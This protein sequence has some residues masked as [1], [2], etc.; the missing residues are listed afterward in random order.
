MKLVCRSL[1]IVISTVFASAL[2]ASEYED[3]WYG[4]QKFLA[5]KQTTD[6][7]FQCGPIFK[8]K[9]SA[10]Y[11]YRIVK[12]KSSMVL[13]V[14]EENQ[15]KALDAKI[16]AKLI[17]IK[18]SNDSVSIYDLDDESR[19]EVIA[20]FKPFR[21]ERTGS[22][23]DYF[24]IQNKVDTETRIN[25]SSGTSSHRFSR[26]AETQKIV[27]KGTEKSTIVGET[28]VT[29]QSYDIRSDGYEYSC[30]ALKPF[31]Q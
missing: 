7:F 4:Y 16:G 14:I 30:R 3:T 5:Q 29:S 31:E 11:D 2:T 21:K 22:F 10:F 27:V 24:T 20:A 6:W 8:D 12:T 28:Y 15:W 25:L 1:S 19:K 18:N 26:E 17:T 9:F 23:W 13:Y